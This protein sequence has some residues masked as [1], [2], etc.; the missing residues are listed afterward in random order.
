M[1]IEFAVIGG[2]GLTEIEGLEVIHREVVHTPYGE[3]SGPVTHGMIAG[4][5]IV[6]LARHG[7]THN[8]PP[9]KVN[10]RANL[11]ALKSLGVEKVVAM[12]AVGGITPE[13]KPM[14]LVIP[15]QIIDYT[16]GRPHTFFEEGLTDVTHID[17]SWPYCP[18]VR[19]ALLAAAECAQLDVVPRGTY[20]A[21]Q[22]PRLETV[23]EIAR[24]ERDGCDLVGMT[25]MPEASLARELGLCYASCAVVANWAAGKDSD[26]ITMEEIQEN[27]L[28][29]MANAR[30]LLRA[31]I[32]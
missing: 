11:W 24:L 8:I 28:V 30:A 15:D 1:T 25:A 13:M 4:K 22:G 9:H 5:R 20:A 6:F 26:E 3:P 16:Y 10:Y 31:L 32:C 14:R 23:A 12:A 2:T 17:F 18:E 21:T 7:Y 19:N 29:G 27:L